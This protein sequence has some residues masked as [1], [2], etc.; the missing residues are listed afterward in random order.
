MLNL[1]DC[2]YPFWKS[3]LVVMLCYKHILLSYAEKN[4]CIMKLNISSHNNNVAIALSA[5]HI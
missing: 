5:H 2:F 3:E 4:T 1:E